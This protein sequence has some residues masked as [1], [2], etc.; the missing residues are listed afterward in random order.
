ML[1]LFVDGQ[2]VP[3]SVSGEQDGRL[4]A[5]DT[6]EFYGHGSGYCL[7]RSEDILAG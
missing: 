3:I 5:G 2:Q 6:V 1:Q 4:D 7:D